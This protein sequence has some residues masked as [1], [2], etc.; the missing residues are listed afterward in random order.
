MKRIV[1]ITSLVSAFLL[2]VPAALSFL[3]GLGLL[4][5]GE[6]GFSDA[7]PWWIVFLI[8]GAG[9]GIPGLL[10]LILS[11]WLFKKEGLVTRDSVFWDYHYRN[12]SGHDHS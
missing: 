1:A 8:L 5:S 12:P 11:R 7:A 4:I 6:D 9:L 3:Y 10:F 2:L